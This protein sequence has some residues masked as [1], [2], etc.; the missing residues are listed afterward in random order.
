MR[1]NVIRRHAMQDTTLPSLHVPVPATDTSRLLARIRACTRRARDT[2][3]PALLRVHVPLPKIDPWTLWHRKAADTTPFFLWHDGRRGLSLAAWGPLSE[4]GFAAA[5]PLADAR[6]ACS[7]LL[8]QVVDVAWQNGDVPDGDV[9]LAFA[10]FAFDKPHNAA[11][12]ADAPGASSAWAGWEGGAMYVPPVTVFRRQVAR[13]LQHGALINMWVGED[14]Q[15]EAILRELTQILGELL[16]KT[17]PRP[18]STTQA[19]LS[20]QLHEPEA[21]WVQR[22]NAAREVARQGDVAKIVLVRAANFEAPEGTVFAPRATALALRD[23]HPRSVCF[24]WGRADGSCFVGASPE[25]LVQVSGRDVTTQAVAGT[26]P[27]GTS[28]DE[29]AALGQELLES[30]K[31]RREQAVV[32]DVLR[33]AL[34][35]LCVTLRSSRTPRLTRFPTVQHLETPFAG[36]L[37]QAGGILDIVERLHPTPSVGG[38]PTQDAL[39]WL[40]K[41]EPVDRGWYA[42][43]VGWLTAGGDGVFTVAIRSVLVRGRR[44]HAF[45]GAGIVAASD[46][47]AEWRETCLKLR[48]VNDALRVRKVP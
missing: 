3:V 36:K 10:G 18:Q 12:A 45:T 29:D 42:G 9:P 15:P 43:P 4:Q 17:Q 27:R 47:A 11:H 1:V 14:A 40:Q 41:H 2:G 38:W 7:R 20:P 26:A 33:Q 16:Q 39:A 22:V 8:E 31:D 25:I 5:A 46:A 23:K 35:P 44:A 48:T 6:R 34:R 13:R 24:A 28:E 21:A 37:R 19:Q 30:S 32:S